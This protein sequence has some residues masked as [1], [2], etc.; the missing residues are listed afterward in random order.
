MITFI[1]MIIVAYA[2]NKLT[3]LYCIFKYK[4]DISFIRT[5]MNDNVT[6]NLRKNSFDT[7]SYIE[8][9]DLRD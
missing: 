9:V 4:N 7:E 1:M 5:I 8:G 2:T 3:R 6:Y